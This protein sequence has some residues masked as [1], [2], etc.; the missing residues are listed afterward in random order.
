NDL[1]TEP[2]NW[3]FRYLPLSAL[4][5][6]PFYLMGFDFGFIVFNLI[7]LIL[8]ILICIFLYKI[9]NLVRGKDHETDEKRVVLYICL[10]MISL[11]QIFNY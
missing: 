8:N 10:Y 2:Y 3:P 6:I 1:Y 9:I 7:N 5:F 11:P 4:Y